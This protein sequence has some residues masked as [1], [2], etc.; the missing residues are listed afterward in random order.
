M[1]ETGTSNGTA[2]ARFT[3]GIWLATEPVRIVGM[4]L[5]STMA[6]VELPGSRVLLYSPVP[7]TNERRAA[8][9]ALGTVAHLYAPNTFHHMWIGEWARAFPEA[10][11]HGPAA[12]RRKRPDLRI[13]RAHDQDPPGELAATFDEVHIDGLRLEE[14]ALVHR[15]SKTLFVADLVHNVG[16]PDQRWA[17]F[18]TKA[19]GFYD[20]VAISRML[21]W[22]AFSDSAR[23]RSSVDRL[24]S[25]SFDRIVFGHGDPLARNGRKALLGA[26]EW[27]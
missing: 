4:K 7:M 24:A 13:D 3:D 5:T 12:L 26:Y 21:R 18:Y 15:A 27:L 16:R 6:A 17:V 10:H 20:R 14:S 25:H 23:A 11:V 19:M 8:V 2:L 9:E 22:T 1:D